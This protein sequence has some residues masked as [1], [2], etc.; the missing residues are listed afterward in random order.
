[1]DF[2]EILELCQTNLAMTDSINH[3]KLQLLSRDHVSSQQWQ[4]LARV[5]ALPY[6]HQ[7]RQTL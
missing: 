1:M 5:P 7:G 3:K 4:G 2:L 6:T